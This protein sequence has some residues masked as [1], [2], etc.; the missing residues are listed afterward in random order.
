[1]SLINSQCCF[2]LFL[3]NIK[4]DLFLSTN[5]SDSL[6]DISTESKKEDIPIKQ[7]KFVLTK[8]EV[9][10]INLLQK[11]TLPKIDLKNED[12][13][14]NIGRWNKDEQKSFAEAVLKF[15]NDW[16]KIQNHIFSRNITQVRSHAQ[17]FLMKLKENDFIKNKGVDQTMSWTK[18]MNYLRG[19]LNHD[20]LKSVL[21]SVEKS[22]DKKPTKKKSYKNKKKKSDLNELCS[23]CSGFSSSCDTRTYFFFEDELN[24]YKYDNKKRIIIKEEDK[25]EI[26]KKYIECFNQKSEE[27]VLNTSFE[28]D[29][30]NE[31]EK[32]YEYFND[33]N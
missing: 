28:E 8:E 30:N 16:R 12:N 4:N 15:G 5:L 29:S 10:S 6:N 3:D 23:D 11:K 27:I 19:I 21:F 32:Q 7:I 13:N 18:T 26:L 25:E 17:K 20:E 1:M 2:P 33:M 22:D 31:N 24:K 9:P 14:S